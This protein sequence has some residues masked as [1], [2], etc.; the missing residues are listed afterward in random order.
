MALCAY[1]KE[2]GRKEENDEKK[3]K[4]KK[5]EKAVSPHSGLYYVEKY[6]GKKLNDI[7]SQWRR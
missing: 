1:E 5:K 3:R 7:A 4:G 6:L 2:E